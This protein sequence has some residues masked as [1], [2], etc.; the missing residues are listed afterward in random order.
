MLP[1]EL[2]LAPGSARPKLGILS[3]PKGHLSDLLGEYLLDLHDRWIWRH[4]RRQWR[5]RT[6]MV[7]RYGYDEHQDEAFNRL[8]RKPKDCEAT[9]VAKDLGVADLPELKPLLDYA[10]IVDTGGEGKGILKFGRV[11]E[12]LYD[13]YPDEPWRVAQFAKLV[14]DASVRFERSVGAGT[15]PPEDPRL[16]ADVIAVAYAKVEREFSPDELERIRPLVTQ[17]LGG[18]LDFARFGLPYCLSLLWWHFQGF[19]EPLRA[20]G[21]EWLVAWAADAVRAELVWQRSYL[22]AKR[23]FDRAFE[24]EAKAGTI[25]PL[26]MDHR[27]VYVACL[28]VRSDSPRFHS[29]V[30]SD[31]ATVVAV[32]VRRSTG[33]VQIFRRRHGKPTVSLQF[34]AA[35]LRAKEQEKQGC[36]ISPWGDLIAAH[37]PKGAE[38]WFYHPQIG[39]ILNRLPESQPTRLG[40][41]E[42]LDCLSRGLADEWERF[43][44]AFRRERE[45]SAA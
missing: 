25:D 21:K 41:R 7:G 43:R 2:H 18:D 13:V 31:M 10:L 27:G 23:E 3:H 14:F 26:R 9:L 11:V 4:Q 33:H 29:A 32:A 34:V 45:A 37:G 36:P 28:L 5:P 19:P 12:L 22:A 42:I 24:A 17:W 30:F 40:N 16:L 1:V 20:F 6:V 35:L 15:V 38:C 44:K 8:G 39:C